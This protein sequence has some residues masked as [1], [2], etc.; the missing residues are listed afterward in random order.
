MKIKYRSYDY[1]ED[2]LKI[3]DGKITREETLAR[4][5]GIAELATMIAADVQK[6]KEAVEAN[7][8]VNLVIFNRGLNFMARR[9]CDAGSDVDS[10]LELCA[11]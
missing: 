5:A 2:E 3:S 4:V 9:L 11:E 6:M 10:T 1:L 7:G 8:D